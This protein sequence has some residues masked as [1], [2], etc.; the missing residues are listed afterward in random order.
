MEL[1]V[2]EVALC[3][4]QNVARVG[5][6][7]VAAV[8][9]GCH[10]LEFALFKVF[11]L[12]FVVA[13]Y[14]AGFI[15]ADGFPTALG[16]VFV[17]QT[18]LDDLELQL[19]YCTHNAAAV[20]L[21]GE[22]LCHTFVHQLLNTLGQLFRLHWVG[23]LDVFEHLW[24]ET[25]Y[26]FEVDILAAAQS[27]AYLEGAVAVGQ[28]YNVARIGLVDRLLLLGHKGRWAAEL[29]HLALAHVLVVH[30][31]LKFPRA[32]LYESYTTAVVGVH[33][34]VYLEH[35]TREGLLFWLYLALHGLR[36]LRAW[37]NLAETVQQFL[38]TEVVQRRTEEYRRYIARQIGVDVKFRIYALY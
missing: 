4:L 9:V 36:R 30:V 1:Y 32:Y 25:W 22:E 23:V 5:K 13:F 24:R 17:L 14:P 7:H 16:V 28:T 37:C 2:R 3:H 20:E 34:G 11:Q 29:H 8:F 33:V 26:S 10:I 21:V 12:G 6:E 31:T 15:Q 35:K 19:A 38:D 18:V 27:V